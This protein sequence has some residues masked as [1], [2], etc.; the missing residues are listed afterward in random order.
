[1]IPASSQPSINP[2]LVV[3]RPNPRAS[4][5]L[6]CF[7]YAGS[8]AVVYRT[9]PNDLS[10]EIEL[11]AA[12][13]PGRENRFRE[14]PRHD[15]TEVVSELA[16]AMQPYLHRP[17]AFFGH[18][19]GGLI[20]FELA[21]HLRERHGLTPLRLFVSA[22]RAPHLP[23]PFPP[24][25]SLPDA[26][27]IAQMQKRYGGIPQVILQTPELLHAM[28]PMLRADFALFEKYVY[29][30]RMPLEC[31][32]IAFGGE[33]DQIVRREEVA[34]WH[35]HTSARFTLRMVEGDHFFVRHAQS[36]LVR[37]VSQ[38]LLRACDTECI[39]PSE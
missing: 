37:E 7:P 5:R 36:A 6:F 28:L 3:P 20:A 13:L 15:L 31:P 34:A 17:F 1:M 21:H 4:I 11:F 16:A 14:T 39:T 12:Q 10:A 29:R 2:W 27:F 22:R 18:S 38:Q 9:W 24:I 30:A 8:G 32:I 35:E 33:Y 23:E 26:E 25:H 19:L